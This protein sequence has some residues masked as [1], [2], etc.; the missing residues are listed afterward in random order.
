MNSMTLQFFDDIALNVIGNRCVFEI[1]LISNDKID[2]YR[3][4][5]VAKDCNQE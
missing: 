1:K 4:Q 3:A 5:R 2:R